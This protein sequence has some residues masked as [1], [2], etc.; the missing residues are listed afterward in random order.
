MRDTHVQGTRFWSDHL[1]MHKSG[2]KKNTTDTTIRQKTNLAAAAEGD[3]HQESWEWTLEENEQ[4]RRHILWESK[5][6]PNQKPC[7]P[8]TIH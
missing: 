6:P 8:A 2:C 4:G 3:K 7:C 5:G 1:I